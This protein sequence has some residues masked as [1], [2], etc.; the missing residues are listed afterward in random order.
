MTALKID[1]IEI[2]V[3]LEELASIVSAL[4]DHVENQAVFAKMALHPSSRVRVEVA[5]KSEISSETAAMLSQDKSVEVLRCIARNTSFVKTATQADV[6]RLIS[7][8]DSEICKNLVGQAGDFDNAEASKIFEALAASVDPDVRLAVAENWSAPKK[9]L[10][11]LL[12]DSD[13]DVR[14]AAKRDD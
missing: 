5:Y 2:N 11:K 1:D 9:V 14:R 8:G 4:K 13:P 7:I 6:D 3:G 10:K 12:N